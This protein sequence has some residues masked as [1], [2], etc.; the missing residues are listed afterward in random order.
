MGIAR[1]MPTSAAADRVAESAGHRA[2]RDADGLE[3]LRQSA[4]CRQ[5]HDLRR[6]KCGTG[7]D[8]VREKDGLWAVLLW[9][10]IIAVSGKGVAEI[11]P[12]SFG[13][14]LAATTISATISRIWIQRSPKLS[15]PIWRARL[16]TLPGQNFAGL[17][18]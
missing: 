8:H 4:R 17:T 16:S 7:S 1:S 14:D 3:I 11:S 5:G 15:W 13:R 2:L 18:V 12:R 6:G 10:N 9:L